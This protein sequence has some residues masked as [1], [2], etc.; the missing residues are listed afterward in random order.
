MPTWVR[1]AIIRGDAAAA[2]IAAALGGLTLAVIAGLAGDFGWTALGVVALVAGAWGVAWSRRQYRC[3][4]SD[5]AR[6]FEGYEP[7]PNP[8]TWISD[9]VWLDANR[10]TP[11]LDAPVELMSEVD[12]AVRAFR[13]DAVRAFEDPALRPV[14]DEERALIPEARGVEAASEV[15]RGTAEML[16]GALRAT[17]GRFIAMGVRFPV[18]CGALTTLVGTRPEQRPAGAVCLPPV[19]G[20]I[21]DA[22]DPLAGMH[23]FTCKVCGRS[24]ATDPSWG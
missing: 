9:E 20:A 18:C 21:E 1:H 11:A 17:P 5:V 2:G 22:A 6:R 16:L 3:M 23:A 24:Y 10:F 4:L 13:D 7:P 12:P 19:A 15:K 14:S 8:V